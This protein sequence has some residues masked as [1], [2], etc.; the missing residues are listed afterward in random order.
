[1]GFP[2]KDSAYITL[3]RC[4]KLGLIQNGD[5]VRIYGLDVM[6]VCVKSFHGIHP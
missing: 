4:G 1:M 6:C 3:Q 2:P 5:V